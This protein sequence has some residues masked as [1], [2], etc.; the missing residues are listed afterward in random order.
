MSGSCWE[1]L[2]EVLE[3]PWMSGSGRE[4]LTDIREMSG[5]PPR[6]PEVFE[7]HSRMSGSGWEALPDVR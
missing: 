7:S 5:G 4:A 1:A 3:A 2:T 6:C